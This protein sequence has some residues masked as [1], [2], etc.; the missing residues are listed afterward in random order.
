MT[1][2]DTA[3]QKVIVSSLLS[4][5]YLNLNIVGEEDEPMEIDVGSKKEL[6]DTML[7]SEFYLPVVLKESDDL[8]E[9]PDA[10]NMDEITIYVDPLDGTRE[11]VEGQLSNVQCLIGLCWHGRPLTGAIGLPFGSDKD[12]TSTEVVFGLVG[13]G[14]GKLFCSKADTMVYE[15]CSVPESNAY[16]EGSTIHVLSGDS[17]SDLPAIAVAERVFEKEGIQHHI[18]G[19]CRNK[20]LRQTQGIT[21]VLQHIK[22]CLWDT[23]APLS[24]LTAVGGKVTDFFGF[25]LIYGTNDVLGNQLGVVSSGP[26]AS[27]QHDELTKANRGEKRL[28]SVLSKFVLCCDDDSEQCV[29]IVRDLDGHPL[30]VTYF[31]KHVNIQA[32]TY[33]CPESCNACRVH[34]QPTKQTVFYKRVEFSHLEHAWTK[35]QTAPHK[36][37]R[38]EY[39]MYS[40]FHLPQT[41]SVLDAV[42]KLQM[43]IHMK[44]K[45]HFLRRKH[46]KQ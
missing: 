38:G 33:S 14:I 25:L 34:L 37:T 19:G 36:L 20:L 16:F 35:L 22:T 15:A 7:D 23:T 3:A 30:P 13:K 21:L 41:L 12:E 4:K 40:L 29:D 11:F 46:V 28:L 42:L 43:S 5:Y 9:P 24:V 6:N 10:L 17:S 18:A 27:K 32:D 44:L 39:F 2:A 31:A 45:R 1:I 26:G 8:E